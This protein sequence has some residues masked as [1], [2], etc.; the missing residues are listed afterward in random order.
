MTTL[1]ED[2]VPVILFGILAEA[3]LAVALVRTGR[4]VL[5]APMGIVA[6]LTLGGV[7]LE[8]L[9][10]TDRE[11][12]ENTLFSAA[13]AIERNDVDRLFEFISPS[14]WYTPERARSVLRQYRFT[15]ARITSV[16]IEVNELTSPPTATAKMIGAFT[17]VDSSGQVPH[18]SG[19]IGLSVDLR[20]EDGRWLITGHSEGSLR[21]Y[22]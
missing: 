22:L 21:D 17:V 7:W 10:E 9:V 20:R 16:E 12:V 18:G 13:G 4:G 15:E 2:P 11:K 3:V 8:W 14:A 6:A 19:R 1:L 5:L